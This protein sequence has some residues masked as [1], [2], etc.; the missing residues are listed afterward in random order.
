MRHKSKTEHLFKRKVWNVVVSHWDYDESL[1]GEMLI[2]CSLVLMMVKA[3]EV[4]V[5]LRLQ[6]L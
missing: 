5:V 3:V 6:G 1:S 2:V 4:L